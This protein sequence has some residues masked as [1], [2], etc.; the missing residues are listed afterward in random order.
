[1]ERDSTNR[2]LPYTKG[3]I[4]CP[5]HTN[6][7]SGSMAYQS[8]RALLYRIGKSGKYRL[9]SI[10]VYL[11]L[12]ET[13]DTDINNIVNP[14]SIRSIKILGNECDDVR[15][16]STK[17]FVA[18]GLANLLRIRT[19]MFNILRSLFGE[20]SIAHTYTKV[21]PDWVSN[22]TDSNLINGLL[23]LFLHTNGN[24]LNK[25]NLNV[26]SIFD[27]MAARDELL[28]CIFSLKSLT[29]TLQMYKYQQFLSGLFSTLSVCYKYAEDIVIEYEESDKVIKEIKKGTEPVKPHKKYKGYDKVVNGLREIRDNI[30]QKNDLYL[31]GL[32]P[33]RMNAHVN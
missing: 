22:Y 18:W 13:D 12:F 5:E 21:Q 17:E 11:P 14:T 10:R 26:I 2:L 20:Q 25:D 8:A 1:M 16:Y 4:I 6:Y 7:I 9:K 31:H 23:N 28:S 32:I 19:L 27:D 15:K 30:Y 33:F 24:I 3:F 29:T